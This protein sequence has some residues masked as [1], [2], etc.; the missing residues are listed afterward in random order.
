MKTSAFPLP[1]SLPRGRWPRLLA[2]AA[3]AAAIFW[4]CTF[5]IMDRDFW[6]HITAGEVMLQTGRIISVD[7]FAYTREGLPYYASYEWLSQILLSLLYGSGGPVAVI[8]FRGVVAC[9]C[10]GLLLQLARRPGFVHGLLAVWAVV[11]TKGSFLERPQLF[12]FVL[13]SGFLLLAFRFLDADAPRVRLRICAGFVALTFLWVNLHGGAALLGCVVVTLL[14][15]QAAARCLP[16]GERAKHLRTAGLLLCTLVLMGV[17]LFLPPNGANALHYLSQLLSDRT[18]VFIAEFQAREWGL[19][20]RELWPFYGLSA[21]ALFAGRRHTVFN[22]LLLAATAFLSRQAFRH[23]IFFVL[24]AVATC[25]YQFERGPL[26]ERLAAWARGDR[27]AVALLALTAV[28]VLGRIAYVRSYGF[29]RQDN[30][31]GFGQ[32]DLARGAYDFLEREGIRG[33]MFNTYGIGGYL[34]HRGYPDRKVFIDG[35]NV[36]YGF[37]FMARAYAAGASAERWDELAQR[38]GITYAVVDY[39]AIRDEDSL[40]YGGILDA[41]TE[42][43]LVYL[44]DWTAVY[45]RRTP[46]NAPIIARLEYALVDATTLQFRDD[47]PAVKPEQ[48]PALIRELERVR[49]GNPEGIK[50]T[51]ALAKLAL[52]ERRGDEARALAQEARA[53]RPYSPEP[54]AVLAALEVGR[55]DWAAAAAAFTEMLALAGDNYPFIN[56][57][58]V[59]DVYAR[60]GHSW[61][62]AHFRRLQGDPVSMPLS[63][64]GSLQE[65]P[66]GL[67]VNPPADALELREQALAHAAAGRLAEAEAAFHDALKIDP[68]SA[69]GWNN[70]CALLLQRERPADAADACRRAT[71]LLPDYADAHYNL[72]LALLRAGD[73]RGAK[74][75]AALAKRHGR[76]QEAEELLLYIAKR[77]L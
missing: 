11:I 62:A 28:V 34:I 52:R 64:S 46:G 17:S 57:G 55:Q 60:A 67:S 68:G 2:Y 71:T 25:F 9:T 31:F 45:L 27:R 39:D 77:A 10:S 65:V 24:S 26:A 44:D 20:L 72:A 18:I 6:W 21:V 13:F 69:E 36:D 23:E 61:K 33:R 30:L 70:L 29:E 43:P 41:H 19:Y 47:F 35:R 38:H 56:Y 66:A 53:V 42:W 51:L 75:E 5:K 58:F 14:L 8:L 59:A 32:F 63:G 37:E 4:V 12:T 1:F 54:V 3:G 73:T 40:P 76:V 74:D 16:R 50:A 15:A 48:S 7:P 49:A 22:V